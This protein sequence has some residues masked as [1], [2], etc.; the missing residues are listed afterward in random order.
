MLGNADATLASPWKPFF[1]FRFTLQLQLI[2]FKL[3]SPASNAFRIDSIKAMDE[4]QI[5]IY[6]YNKN[7]QTT[8]TNELSLKK[9]SEK[10]A[11][12]GLW[13][14]DKDINNT[15][16]VHTLKSVLNKSD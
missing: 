7:C 10:V 12:N 6:S 5:S 4:L 15:I 16:I 8:Q 9:S 14:K 3:K 13:T 11:N 1:I 2:E